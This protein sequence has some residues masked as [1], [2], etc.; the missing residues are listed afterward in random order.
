MNDLLTQKLP[1][2]VLEDIARRAVAKRKALKIT[3]EQL[4]KKSGVSLGSIKRFERTHQISLASLVSIGFALG[5]EDDFALLFSGE[6]YQSID[7]VVKS[8]KRGRWHDLRA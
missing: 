5:C 7:D 4:A 8:R 6:S 1:S 3:Q 2:E